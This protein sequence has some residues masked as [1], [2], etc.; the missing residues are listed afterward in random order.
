VF[1]FVLCKR[2]DIDCLEA[3]A[4][5]Q[6]YHGGFR[7]SLS[8]CSPMLSM[9]LMSHGFRTVA[10]APAIM[11]LLTAARRETG[12]KPAV[13]KIYLNK[14]LFTKTELAY[15]RFCVVEQNCVT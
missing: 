8:S 4:V 13:S 15:F 1:S 6:T 2:L 3:Y 11:S 9:M 10:G 14:K 5:A 7:L 12:M